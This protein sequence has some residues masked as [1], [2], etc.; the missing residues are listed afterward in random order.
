M[1]GTDKAIGDTLW[2]AYN[3]VTEYADH[4]SARP[5]SP[6]IHLNSIWFGSR[7]TVKVN[8]FRAAEECADEWKIGK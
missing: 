6:A 4:C 8:A 3:A 1:T 7:A 2:T 5:V